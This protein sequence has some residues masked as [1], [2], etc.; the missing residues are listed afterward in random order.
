[1]LAVITLTAIFWYL[2]SVAITTAIG[3]YGGKLL[4]KEPQEAPTAEGDAQSR[5][6][7]PR[8][9]QQVG[10]VRPRA[11]GRNGHHGNIIA[12]WTDVSGTD[13]EILYMIVEHCD[14]PTQGVV[15]E[16]LY[17]K[18]L[19]LAIN[20]GVAVGSGFTGTA[21]GNPE[22]CLDGN[23]DTHYGVDSSLFNDVFQN[24]Y[25]GWAQITIEVT[26]DDTI[27]TLEEVTYHL[28]WLCVPGWSSQTNSVSVYYSGSYHEIG[29]SIDSLVTIEGPWSDVTKMKM[30]LYGRSLWGAE[31]TYMG[32]LCSRFEARV[33]TEEAQQG[34][35][36]IWFNNQPAAN[37][38]S[39][40]IQE[41][42][43]TMGQ[44]CMTGFEKLKL[45][46]PLSIEL[47]L[48]E[49]VIYTT[50]NDFFDDLE[51]TIMWPNGLRKYHKEGG[52]DYSTCHVRVRIRE[53]DT[54]SWTTIFTDGV[55]VRTPNPYFK[56]YKVSDFW[57]D[58]ER[59]KQYDLEF[60]N[61]T[62]IAERHVNSVYIKSVREVVDVPFTYPGKA[63]IGVTALATNKLSG[64]IDVMV[65]REDRIVNV[66][67]GTSWNL[68]YS[69][70]RSWVEYDAFT[71]PVIS[72]EGTGPDPWVIEYYEGLS[73]EYMDLDFFY[74]WAEFCSRQ[75]DDGYGGQEDLCACDTIIDFQT[76]VWEL[77][78]EIAQIGRAYLYWYGNT[79][80][81]YIDTRVSAASI[82]DLVT[83][84]NIMARSWKN[85]WVDDTELA[86]KVEVMFADARRGYERTS[87]PLPNE[88][89]G[90]YTRVVTIEGVGITTRGT[91]IHT[92]NYALERNRL[93]NNINNFRKHKD[94]FRYKLGQVIRVQSKRPD[95][96]EAFRVVRQVAN[97][98]VKFDRHCAAP[99]GNLLW[100]RTFD[101]V[102]KR[103][104]T[105]SYTVISVSNN[106]VTIAETWLS[107]PRKNDSCAVG[108]T[109]DVQTRR[110]IKLDIRTDNY[111][112]VTVETYDTDLFNADDL[113]P[114]NPD[115]HFI[116]THPANPLMK[117]VTWPAIIDMINAMAPPQLDVDAP[118]TSNCKWTG[119]GGDTVAWSKFNAD[120]PILFRY[121]GNS[122]EITADNTTDEFIYWDPSFT[123]TFR[124]TNDAAVAITLGRWYMCRNVAGVAYPTIPFSSIHAGV[125]QVGTIT[126]AYAQI[127]NA[128][129]ETAKIKDLAVETIKVKD[130][131]I[132]VPASVSGTSLV[133]TTTGKNLYISTSGLIWFRQTHPDGWQQ[134]RFQIQ[135]KRD[136]VVIYNTGTLYHWTYLDNQYTNIPWACGITDEPGAD[137]YT[138]TITFGAIE[139]HGDVAFYVPNIFIIETKK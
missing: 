40:D 112:D 11:Y 96:G 54:E 105:D 45:E 13:R 122:Y 86:G 104:R 85:V 2:V 125:L 81:G 33:N 8:T 119:S 123:T 114:D 115:Q 57:A 22:D 3:Y 21:H 71:Q 100:L 9:T 78:N 97:N 29:T 129:I 48:G 52:M 117:P 111:V 103:I 34:A 7:R 113:D 60:Q 118:S 32:I 61:M 74:D 80:T 120:D 53:H 72:G 89:G 58:L 18:D 98:K 63:I 55:S 70:N 110:I 77:A 138:Y 35:A 69:R 17:V 14:G 23:K 108:G 43:G 124:H 25:D 95:W 20:G 84:D 99:A 135:V 107:P 16:D 106:T 133:F 131:A 47:L 12:K 50:H 73:P 126:A 109:S 37:F 36:K 56:A 90:H 44:S 116:W 41:R 136:A 26:F 82:I 42:V 19:A 132:T 134:W 91:A 28:T 102:N 139:V 31:D 101:S 15:Y 94:A 4:A 24:Y 49:P 38:S 6:W 83:M 66:Y 79:L 10:I 92:A 67:D 46:D 128:A 87:C 39:V 130:E 137:T 88:D 27:T 76:N 64:D 121:K 65:I 5:S 62:G 127:A 93:I 75:V 30:V 1:M 51:W 68:E 59:G